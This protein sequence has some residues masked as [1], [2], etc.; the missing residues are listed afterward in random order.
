MQVFFPA[1]LMLSL[2]MHTS[3]AIG[4]KKI[5]SWGFIMEKK[6]YLDKTENKKK[7]EWVCVKKPV[8][9]CRTVN[10]EQLGEIKIKINR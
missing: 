5:G 10:D 8:R 3:F 9:W 6:F 4:R 7:K 2:K 1:N